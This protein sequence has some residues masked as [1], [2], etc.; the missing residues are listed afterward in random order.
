V[1]E[2]EGRIKRLWLEPEQIKRKEKWMLERVSVGL[3]REQEERERQRW[4]LHA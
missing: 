1:E 2:A 3:H 4:M